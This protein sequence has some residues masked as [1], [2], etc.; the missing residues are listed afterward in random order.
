M[1]KFI[2]AFLVVFACTTW[3]YMHNFKERNTIS[4]IRELS[5]LFSEIAR[6]I[7]FRLEP[8]TQVIH[9]LASEKRSAA[10]L[11]LHQLDDGLSIGDMP[12]DALWQKAASFFAK[13]THLPDQ[14]AEILQS[15]GMHLGKMDYEAEVNRLT[16]AAKELKTLEEEMKKNNLKTEKTVKSL[17]VLLGLFIVIILL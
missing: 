9:R 10:A 12:F 5:M 11:F 2:G 3:G 15:V 16:E 8:L 14:A 1:T 13:E 4:A 17:G 7:S 6:S